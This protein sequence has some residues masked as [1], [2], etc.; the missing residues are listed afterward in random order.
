MAKTQNPCH[1]CSAVA[2]PSKK[3]P[4][5]KV[6]AE[7]QKPSRF[8]TPFFV[9]Y[10]IR[11]VLCATSNSEEQLIRT[12]AGIGVEAWVRMFRSSRL[13]RHI[14]SEETLI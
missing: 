7:P 14:I 1:R 13:L 6:Y 5:L 9:L 8:H 10:P 4:W 3:C 11:S 12:S 2:I